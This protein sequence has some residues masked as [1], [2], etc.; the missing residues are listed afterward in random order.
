MYMLCIQQQGGVEYQES[1][2]LYGH[3]RNLRRDLILCKISPNYGVPLITNYHPLNN[4]CLFHRFSHSFS[5]RSEESLR[6]YVVVVINKRGD[7][8]NIFAI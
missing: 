2:F 5:L 8:Q 1:T 4:Y 7:R 6:S 3:Y